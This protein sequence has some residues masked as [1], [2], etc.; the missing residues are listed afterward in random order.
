MRGIPPRD[1]SRARTVF[2]EHT[3][4]APT[5][6]ILSE[7]QREA[8]KRTHSIKQ[9]VYFGIRTPDGDFIMRGR[10]EEQHQARAEE[11]A[12]LAIERA[13]RKARLDEMMANHA[14]K[15]DHWSDHN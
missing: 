7:H 10:T 6:N 4:P 1:P 3:F 8:A 13:E 5:R 12:N 9:R 2:S 11:L 15:M 14:A